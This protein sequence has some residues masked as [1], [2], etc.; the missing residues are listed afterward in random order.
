[1]TLEECSCQLKKAIKLTNQYR[2]DRGDHVLRKIEIEAGQRVL[3]LELDK[4]PKILEILGS[5]KALSTE[6]LA[7]ITL[8]VFTE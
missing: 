8:P 6:N 2:K 7:R 1:M 3:K 5:E 4:N